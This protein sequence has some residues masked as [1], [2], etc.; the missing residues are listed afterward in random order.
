MKRQAEIV[1]MD[2]LG[3]DFLVDDPLED[4]GHHEDLTSAERTSGNA[5]HRIKRGF[6]WGGTGGVRLLPASPSAFSEDLV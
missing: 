5:R 6:V 1:F 2:D 3:R 4:G